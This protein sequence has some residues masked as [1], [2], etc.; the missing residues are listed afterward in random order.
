MIGLVCGCVLLRSCR[1]TRD[2]LCLA[3]ECGGSGED[4]SST[5]RCLVQRLR[6]DRSRALLYMVQRCTMRLHLGEVAAV[7]LHRLSGG[8]WFN[9][10]ALIVRLAYST[11]GV[12][13]RRDHISAR[14]QR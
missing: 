3:S 9:C 11:W 5:R 1:F 4:V 2:E 8:G 12:D 14:W 6:A 13:E 10:D 7:K